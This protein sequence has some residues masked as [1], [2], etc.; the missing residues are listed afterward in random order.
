M[1]DAVV[2][3]AGPNGLVAANHLAAA[4]WSVTVLEASDEP[5]GA[6]RSGELTLPGFRHDLCS[7]F[8]PLAAAS[9]AIVALRLEDHGLRWRRSP[10]V[11]ANPLPDGA[12]VSL[13]SDLDATAASV[14]RFASGDGASWR[15][16]IEEWRRIA[17]PLL[18]AVLGPFPPV[19]A[20][21]RLFTILGPRGA[22]RL[23]RQLLL[24]VRRMA[25]ERFGGEG[26]GLLLA[27]CGLHTDLSP[28]SAG[29]GAFG[30][31]LCCLGQEHGFPV[32]EGGAGALTAA[33]TRR[34]EAYGGELRCG[35]P[36]REVVVRGGRVVGVRT[37]DGTLVGARRAVLADV[38]A[39]ALFG[40]LVASRHL[41]E[42]VLDDVGRFQWDMST[43]KVDWA[44]E[45][46]VPWT[47]EDARR[48]G[49]VH[50]ADDLDQL[51]EFA[52]H[53]AMG[54]LPAR[55]FVLFGQQSV[56]DPTRSPA[57]TETA[58]AYTHV[59]RHVRGDAAGELPVDGSEASWLEGFVARLEARI[60]ERAP[61]FRARIL[62]RHVFGPGGLEALDA[63][64]VGGAV[65][66]GTSQLH[67][68]LL[69]RPVPGAGRPETP[70]AGL[71]LA[72]ASAHP[73]GGVHGACGANAARAALRAGGRLRSVVFGGAPLRPGAT[74]RR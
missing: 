51:T 19:G 29:S 32:P 66:G 67:Q 71:Y 64:L 8:Y 44:L 69:L 14:E 57:G 70:I 39:P 27:G 65:N 48:A 72:S 59:P 4:G 45:T 55:P 25:E 12:C 24:P 15:L 54:R 46:P 58:W 62:A 68:Q 56:S 9:P 73:G 7:A 49:T 42:S 28:E 21:A 53:V 3:G 35:S 1:D 26:A 18:A 38:A 30:W 10:L 17:T 34:L 2:I 63:N 5:G 60:E 37:A 31:L 6:V 41:P 23:V 40:G 22:L 36:V 16:M 47:A 11:L 33:L 50:V 43:V 52:A 13:S 74:S 20:V 61:G